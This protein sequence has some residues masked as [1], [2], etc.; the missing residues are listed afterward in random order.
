MRCE[1]KSPNPKLEKVKNN[2]MAMLATVSLVG[3]LASLIGFFDPSTCIDNQVEGW[4]SCKS[5]AEQR[6]LGSWLLLGFSALGF[7]V[8][9][10]RRKKR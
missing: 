10:T 4:T 6:E 3:A 2:S 5:I 9:V 7:G 1:L 8:S